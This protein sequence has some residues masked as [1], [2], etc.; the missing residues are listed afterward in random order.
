M[1]GCAFV[2]VT[3]AQ[4]AHR[5][6]DGGICAAAAALPPAKVGR[7]A[8]PEQ[9]KVRCRP[10]SHNGRPPLKKQ[11]PRSSGLSWKQ[12]VKVTG[13]TF[14]L[15]VNFANAF[16]AAAVPPAATGRSWQREGAGKAAGRQRDPHP[17]RRR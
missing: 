11:K 13:V 15:Q 12:A 9:Q 4:A 2:Q 14:L 7:R 5:G 8:R 6:G 1:G 17:G 16:D 3:A 10:A